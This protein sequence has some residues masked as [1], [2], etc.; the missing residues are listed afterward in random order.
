MK[1]ILVFAFAFLS[2]AAAAAQKCDIPCKIDLALRGDGNAA[3]EV[4]E[5]SKRTQTHEIIV[6]WYKISAENGNAQGQDGYAD[7]LVADSTS[8]EDCIRALYWYGKAKD[9]GSRHAASAEASLS[10]K[11]LHMKEEGQGC[12][13][14][15]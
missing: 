10:A 8:K 5:E 7:L 12:G 2:A 11:L 9:G 4:A 3:F 14:G 1:S 15:L 6:F 13:G